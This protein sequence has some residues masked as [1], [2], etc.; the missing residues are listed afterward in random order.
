MTLNRSAMPV[1]PAN[2]GPRIIMTTMKNEGPFML[3]WVA[4]N[5]TIGFTG[6]VI[7]T[8]DCEDGTDLIAT[9]LE[10]LGYCSHRPNPV[11]DGSPPQH[12]A[13]RRAIFHP[14]VQQAEWLMC[15]DVDEFINLREGLK[16]LDDLFAALGDCDAVSLAWK[17][18]GCG[19]IEEYSDTP[20]TR[21]FI[22]ADAE[23]DPANGRA[24]G[25]KTLFRNNGLF[26]KYNPH[27]PKGVPEGREAQ[28]RWS[29]CGGNLRPMEKISWRAWPGFSHQYARLHHYS[30]R[31]IDS[32]LVKRDRGRT[33]HIAREQTEH[34]WADMN[35]NR[36]EDRSIL[37]HA[38]RARSLL[39]AL[40]ADPVL[41]RLHQEAC[42][43]HRA[44]I[45]DLRQRPGWEEFR[46]WL[47][48]NA[49]KT[50]AMITQKDY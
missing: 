21:Q 34:Y 44:R 9:R 28:V 47:R 49:I 50:T 35:V 24:T 42:D 18:F 15:L 41:G 31:S 30:V 29:D 45:A 10:E 14:W 22:L 33:N 6:F 46:D 2:G 39:D 19:G 40:R 20:M 48:A 3:E 16:T 23:D 38:D 12:K 11:T 36:T 17:L 13:L 1:E 37:P 32:F 7:F 26:R 5:L 4:H 25:F 43:W 8:N 27:R